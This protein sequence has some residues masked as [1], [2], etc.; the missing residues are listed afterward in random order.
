MKFNKLMKI[1]MWSMVGCTIFG[2]LPLVIAL[3]V[4]IFSGTDAMDEATGTGAW[5]WLM[6]ISLPLGFILGLVGF[7]L[8]LVGLLKKSPKGSDGAANR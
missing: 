2:F 3:I 7:V 8:F 6:Y 4:G 5:L 1:G